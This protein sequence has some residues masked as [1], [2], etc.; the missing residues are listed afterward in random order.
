M[1]YIRNHVANFIEIFIFKSIISY[2]ADFV[3]NFFG[4]FFGVGDRAKGGITNDT[5]GAEV[6]LE[7]PPSTN[8]TSSY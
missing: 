8:W 5:P 2:I 7:Q 1:K 4:I 3:I 6:R